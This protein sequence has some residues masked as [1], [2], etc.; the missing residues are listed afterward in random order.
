MAE[1]KAKKVSQAPYATPDRDNKTD[2]T[3]EGATMLKKTD[4]PSSEK[5]NTVTPLDAVPGGKHVRFGNE[6][7]VEEGEVSTE[8]GS[9]SKR[10]LV[11][12]RGGRL[13]S[14]A[15][16]RP[17]PVSTDGGPV[18]EFKT[19]RSPQRKRD[20]AVTENDTVPSLCSAN[21]EISSVEPS[22]TLGQDTGAVSKDADQ[23]G[24]E[25]RETEM[26]AAGDADTDGKPDS[27]RPSSISCDASIDASPL[28]SHDGAS[29]SGAVTRSKGSA[30][31]PKAAELAAEKESQA[32][33]RRNVT[34]SP[35]TPQ[36]EMVPV[37]AVSYSSI[38]MCL[39]GL[40]S[41]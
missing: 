41:I 28:T 30:S 12:R 15:P 23:G 33:G 9:G 4:V 14:P 32:G 8:Q 16:P 17:A 3:P 1:T 31:T 20:V 40:A 24:A 6:E 29:P 36:S 34:F 37:D 5:P 26:A 35:P 18:L 22:G 13:G 38:L 19:Y 7:K 21:S 39:V 11:S 10:G 27:G 25:R 2:P